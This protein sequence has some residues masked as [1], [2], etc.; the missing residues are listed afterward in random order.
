MFA[1][2]RHVDAGQAPIH[3]YIFL[4]RIASPA[5]LGVLNRLHA[6]EQYAQRLEA[7]NA[8]SSERSQCLA[9]LHMCSQ[10]RAHTSWHRICSGRSSLPTPARSNCHTSVDLQV[11]SSLRLYLRMQ[12]GTTYMAEHA[13][14]WSTV[15]LPWR[16]SQVALLGRQHTQVFALLASK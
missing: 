16:S 8:T 9:V 7:C 3:P 5:A 6:E 14:E 1:S 15:H 12:H 10:T 4:D 11:N 2:M 13:T